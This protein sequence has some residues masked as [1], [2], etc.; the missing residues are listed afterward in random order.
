MQ[1]VRTLI[2]NDYEWHIARQTREAE[3]VARDAALG[4]LIHRL[5]NGTLSERIAS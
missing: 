2:L 4:E 3:D 1:M 5:Q